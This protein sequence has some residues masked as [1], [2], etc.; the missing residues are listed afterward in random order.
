M[1]ELGGRLGGRVQSRGGERG[2]EFVG[3]RGVMGT[4]PQEVIEEVDVEPWRATHSVG[5]LVSG[6]A[7]SRASEEGFCFFQSLK[8]AS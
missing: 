6:C 5:A 2:A 1:L 7:V 4:C 3:S 8:V